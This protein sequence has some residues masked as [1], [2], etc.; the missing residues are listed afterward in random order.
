MVFPWMGSVVSSYE[1][2]LTSTT[3]FKGQ[4]NLEQCSIRHSIAIVLAELGGNNN[5][6]FVN[7]AWAVLDP[8]LADWNRVYHAKKD[9]PAWTHVNALIEKA[10]HL[11]QQVP[12]TPSSKSQEVTSDQNV[13]TNAKDGARQKPHQDAGHSQIPQSSAMGL[14][15]DLAWHSWSP[16]SSSATIVPQYQQS[17]HPTPTQQEF[18]T[19]APPMISNIDVPFQTG[20]A[21]VMHGFES[22]DF[23]YIDGLDSIDFSAFDAV[24]K[25]M[26]WDFSSPSTDANFEQLN[27]QAMS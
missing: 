11:R 23:G 8:I 10:R 20:C 27:A 6:H 5:Q 17:S 3:A 16:S 9:E 22:A 19:F 26:A 12:D 21:P 25:D 13:S 2:L 24:F 15:P 4:A 14:V 18:Q 1:T 7:T